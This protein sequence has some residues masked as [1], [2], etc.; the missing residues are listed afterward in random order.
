MQ[1]KRPFFYFS[2]SRIGTSPYMYICTSDSNSSW[3]CELKM[4][5]SL[6][7]ICL[8]GLTSFQANAQDGS[9][10]D[11]CQSF[12]R[13]GICPLTI[14]NVLEIDSKSMKTVK[15]CQYS[16]FRDKL[17]NHFTFFKRHGTEQKCV[18]FKECPEQTPCKSCFTGPGE[19]SISECGD[20]TTPT[21]LSATIVTTEDGPSKT[22]TTVLTPDELEALAIT[23]V[24]DRTTTLSEDETTTDV[25]KTETTIITKDEGRTTDRMLTRTPKQLDVN[26]MEDVDGEDEPTGNDIDEFEVSGID[27]GLLTGQPEPTELPNPA[28]EVPELLPANPENDEDMEIDMTDDDEAFSDDYFDEEERTTSNPDGDTEGIVPRNKVFNCLS[29]GYGPLGPNP[30][31]SPMV[32]TL[33]RRR[34]QIPSLPPQFPLGKEGSM[35]TMM[36]AQLL[37]CSPGAQ[38][39]SS[40]LGSLLLGFSNFQPG[41]CFGFSSELRLWEPVGSPMNTFR[42]GSSINRMGRFLVATGGRGFPQ[43]LNSIEVLNTRNPKRWRTLSKLTMPSPTFD[44]CSVALNK[45][46]IMVTGGVGQESQAIILDLKGKKWNAMKPMKQPRRKHSCIKA[47]VNG[48]DG[49]IVAGGESDAIPDLASLEFYDMKEGNWLSLGRMRQGRRFPGIMT[50][51]GNLVVG[52]GESTDFF[53]QNVF[54]DTMETLRKRTWRPVKQRLETP[55]SRFGFTRVPRTLFF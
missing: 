16:C 49:V 10:D 54:L 11:P 38:R 40:L 3:C 9:T 39:G 15:E 20:L 27:D 1:L 30:T 21:E 7:L 8:L 43:P 28:T 42:G 18:H 53:G 55:R 5:T 32:P 35:S 34:V 33:I 36:N 48:R 37:M 19:P 25:G 6:I 2:F 31:I 50:L 24:S 22:T 46:S 41:G 13:G 23:I 47:K 52:G 12:E 14:D 44:H 17:C 26:E 45:T 51:S 29:G 4:F